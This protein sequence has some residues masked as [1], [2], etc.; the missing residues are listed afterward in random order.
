MKNNC[1]NCE[2][3]QSIFDAQHKRTAQADKLWQKAHNKPDVLPDLGE[4]IRW[5]LEETRTKK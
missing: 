5:L 2:E 3:L 1:P 4:L